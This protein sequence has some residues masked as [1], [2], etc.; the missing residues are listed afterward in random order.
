MYKSHRG[1]VSSHSLHNYVCFL[2]VKSQV[3]R[4]NSASFTSLCK[5]PLRRNNCSRAHLHAQAVLPLYPTSP[6]RLILPLSPSLLPSLSSSPLCISLSFLL[7]ED[8]SMLC[9][10]HT[11]MHTITSIRIC[12]HMH[13]TEDGTSPLALQGPAYRLVRSRR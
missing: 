5:S 11:Q 7:L 4:N 12:T 6:L 2:P 13:A 10:A 9:E 1:E 3:Q 8:C